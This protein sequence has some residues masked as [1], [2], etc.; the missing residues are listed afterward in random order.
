MSEKIKYRL[1]EIVFSKQTRVKCIAVLTALTVAVISLLG[2]SI[3]TVKVFDGEKT[4]TVRSLNANAASVISN[5]RL[6]SGRYKILSSKT[7]SRITTVEIAYSFPVYIT[8]G[9][10]TLEIEFTGGTVKEALMLAG[11]TPDEFDMIEPAADT[12]IDKT[13][14][15]DYTDIEYVNGVYT[16]VIPAAE[17]TVYSQAHA[18]GVVKT[19][20]GTDGLKQVTYTEKLVNGVSSEKTVTGEEVLT[21][22]VN[23]K[24]IIGTKKT[25]AAVKQA[26]KTSAD[27]KAVST[28]TPAAS[29]EL[30]ANGA[31]LHYKSKMTSRATAYTYTGH[32][33]ATGV[34]PQP[35]YIA[36]NP[37]VIPYGTKMYIKTADGSVIYGYAVAADTGGFIKNHPT[38]VDL[39][40]ATRSECVSFGVRNVEIYILE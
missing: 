27:V 1:S 32:N 29:I 25:A 21:A 4:Y 40:M 12:V 38:G 2:L 19:E 3:N 34:A 39:F 11:Y 7:E 20:N 15:I 9:E 17:E 33:C 14:Y 5:I 24:K 30:D 31:P 13:V 10:N 6:K 16:E 8:A 37:N 26:V 22:A 28:L 36:V 18:Q 23:T 35:G